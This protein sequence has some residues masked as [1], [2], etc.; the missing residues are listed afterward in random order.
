MGG[1][2]KSSLSFGHRARQTTKVAQEQK[3]KEKLSFSCTTNG[4]LDAV[5]LGVTATAT[6]LELAALSA[7]EGLGI[8]V[9]NTR[10]AE[11]LVGLAGVTGTCV[12][13]KRR[14]K[15]RK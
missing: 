1:V 15:K 14:E 3:N 12:E 2:S 9:G 7:N 13:G 4:N 10:S 5:T 11:V 6:L 8:G